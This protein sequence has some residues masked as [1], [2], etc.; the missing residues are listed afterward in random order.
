MFAPDIEISIAYYPGYGTYPTWIVT[1]IFEN[2]LLE[3]SKPVYDEKAAW[4]LEQD[5][6]LKWKKSWNEEWLFREM[7]SIYPK[8]SKLCSVCDQDTK[9]GASLCVEKIF[10]NRPYCRSQIEVEKKA[11]QQRAA[12][13]EEK[14]K[15]EEAARKIVEAQDATQGFHSHDGWY[16]LRGTDGSIRLTRYAEGRWKNQVFF[17]E[18][19]WA[20]IVA[21]VSKSGTTTER[22]HQ[23]MN[24]H[25]GETP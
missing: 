10:C 18:S 23:A 12:D 17:Q 13:R 16:W 3:E 7:I 6:A 2:T 8:A 19:E 22:Y 11:Y 9:K 21:F 1:A 15:K 14:W 25:S 5:Y 20:S 24:F 4:K